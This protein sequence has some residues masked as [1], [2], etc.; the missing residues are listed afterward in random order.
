MKKKEALGIFILALLCSSLVFGQKH[1]GDKD[2]KWW[3]DSHFEWPKE[4][5]QAKTLPLISVKGNKFINSEGDTLLFRGVAI[6]D[7][8]KLKDQG[9]WRKRHFEEIKKMGATLVRIPVHPIAWHT[10]TPEKYLDLLDE[11]V[12]WCTE[13]GLYVIVDW[14]SIGN[15]GMELFQSPMYDT[16]IKETYTFWQTIAFHFKGNNTVAFYELFNEPTLFNGSL[17]S[18]SWSEW[19]TMNEKMI[20]LLRACDKETIPLV[21][22]FDWAYDLTP[23]HNNPIRAEG[24]GY[25]TH[26]YPHKRKKPWPLKWEENFGFAADTYPVIATEIGF[27]LDENEKGEDDDYGEIIVSYLEDR[28][29]S[30]VVWVFDA[31]WYPGLIKSWDN[32]ELSGCGKFFKKAMHGE[33]VH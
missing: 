4:N 12:Q 26:P 15:L 17:G 29:I 2:F 18:M 25:V 30:W 20:A 6:S 10:R 14:H 13:L 11:A 27:R 33:V 16:T 32:Y 9:L 19:K 8:D 31:D 23:L 22:G 21:A 28:G 24:I 7:P 5:P 3:R 1:P